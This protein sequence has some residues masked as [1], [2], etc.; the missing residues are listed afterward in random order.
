[1]SRT[2][3]SIVDRELRKLGF[4]GLDDP[5]LIP[6]IAFCIRSHEQFRSQ[7]FSVLPERRRLAYEQL[8]PH[9][10]FAAKPLDVYEAEMKEMAE[11]MQLPSYNE[12]TG[13]IIPF[14][15]IDQ[16]A[17]EAISQNAHEKAGGSLELV[18]TACTVAQVWKAARR[19]EAEKQAQSDGWRWAERNGVM[20]TYCPKHV[21][22]RLSM[23][24]RCSECEKVEKVRAWDEQDGYRSARLAGW[25]IGDSAICPKCAV[26]LISIQ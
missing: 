6:Q 18:C 21:P 7:L 17:Q 12:K 4:G 22:A 15:T 10:R 1:M 14:K 26:K 25:V 24:L 9:L 2:D 3:R 5:N 13:E 23:L 19:T 16:V 20:K 11:R 8:R